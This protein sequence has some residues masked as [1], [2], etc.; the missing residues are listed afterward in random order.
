MLSVYSKGGEERVRYEERRGEER[1]GGRG[2]EGMRRG[3][4]RVERG[5]EE[6]RER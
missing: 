5:G 3:E 2:G 6:E 4:E 1:E